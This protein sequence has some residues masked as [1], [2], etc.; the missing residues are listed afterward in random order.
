MKERF[1]WVFSL[2]LILSAC[3]SNTYSELEPIVENPTYNA[4]IKL[5]IDS[6]CI[7]CHNS[8]GEYLLTNY[9]EVKY[10]TQ[11]GSLL[12]RIKGNNCGVMPP[13]PNDNLPQAKI[14][15]V[16]LW[17]TQGYIEQ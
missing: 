17:K 4:N 13:Q 12:C 6:K 2:A 7:S 14:D 1:F 8:N 10:A 15:M 3:D 5:L 16:D 9:S 11:N